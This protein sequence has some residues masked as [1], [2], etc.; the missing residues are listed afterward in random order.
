MGMVYDL[1]DYAPLLRGKKRLRIGNN[2]ELLDLKF[3]FIEGVPPRN[4]ISIQNIYPL[5]EYDGHYGWFLW[6]KKITVFFQQNYVVV[7]MLKTLRKSE[8]SKL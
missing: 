4:P 1:T 2:Q 6:E 3:E 5:G 7:L 8:S